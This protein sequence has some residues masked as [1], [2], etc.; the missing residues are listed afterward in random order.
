MFPWWET[1]DPLPSPTA[2]TST[3][4][5][6]LA[7]CL[8]SPSPPIDIRRLL[9]SAIFSSASRCSATAAPRGR[10]G[11]PQAIRNIRN[12]LLIKVFFLDL[13]VKEAA[14]TNT[15]EAMREL[16]AKCLAHWH[17]I[18]LDHHLFERAARRFATDEFEPS[19]LLGLRP[20]DDPRGMAAAGEGASGGA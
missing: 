2:S 9:M 15:D 13:D 6:P 16:N 7:R 11:P 3:K 5:Q 1:P 8:N 18:S 10:S 12:T 14:T 20:G 17:S 19:L 4:A